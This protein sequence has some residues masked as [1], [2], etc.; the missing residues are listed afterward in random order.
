MVK[1]VVG[2]LVTV[3]L[4]VLVALAQQGYA[5]SF[6][7]EEIDGI[8]ISDPVFNPGPGEAIQAYQRA[9]DDYNTQVDMFEDLGW[10]VIYEGNW[11]FEET[12]ENGYGSYIVWFKGTAYWYESGDP[13]YP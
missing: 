12:Y 2:N 1:K 3:A 10:V 11:I 6:E 5:Q 9:E 4:V 13:V 7:W 8:G